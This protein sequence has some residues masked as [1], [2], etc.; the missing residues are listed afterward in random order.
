MT[1]QF[2]IQADD[3]GAYARQVLARQG[4]DPD[5]QPT[6]EYTIA[7]H[8]TEAY[9]AKLESLTKAMFRDKK[10]TEPAVVEWMRAFVA[11]RATCPNLLLQGPTGSGK[12]HNGYAALWGITLHHARKGHRFTFAKTTHADFNQA[13]RPA[14]DGSHL[15]TLAEFQEVDLLL[16]DD[17]GAGQMTDWSTDTLHRLVDERWAEQRPMIVTTNLTAPEMRNV[18]ND[19]VVSRLL[20]STQVPLEDVDHRRIQ[21]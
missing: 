17:L 1:S 20:H 12:T 2:N 10:P 13:M 5:T 16:F 6:A 11:D 18:L 4:V 15:D 3:I 14:P 8:L 7:D 21:P 19:R 9:R